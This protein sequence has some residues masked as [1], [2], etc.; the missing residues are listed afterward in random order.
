[1][2]RKS[3]LV[4]I[5]A[6]I[7]LCGCSNASMEDAYSKADANKFAVNATEEVTKESLSTT[8]ERDGELDW[9]FNLDVENQKQN[10]LKY[11]EACKYGDFS[12]VIENVIMTTNAND[13]KNI[14][15]KET[16]EAFLNF[17]TNIWDDTGTKFDIDG[18]VSKSGYTCLFI[19]IKIKNESSNII[20]KC[21]NPIFYN[22]NENNTF[23]YIGRAECNAF[24]KYPDLS[25]RNKD[26]LF[27]TFKANEEI[28]TVLLYY[29]KNQQDIFKN[30]YMSAVFLS[31]SAST[32]P[33]D[34][35]LNC[36]M[37]PLNIVNGNIIK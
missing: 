35:P 26:S 6:F 15:S 1:M 22:M 18:N 10:I 25:N 21:M 14:A 28:E 29:I 19:K 31:N 5:L 20:T 7:F 24:D 3:K 8:Y 13:V 27:Y 30:V 9:S 37:L 32:D 34:V 33:T 11:G 23:T 36:Y 2:F 17:I 16:G 12:L 4:F